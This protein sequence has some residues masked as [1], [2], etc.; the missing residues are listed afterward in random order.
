MEEFLSHNG[1]PFEL[2]N[3]FEDPLTPDELFDLYHDEDGIQLGPLTSLSHQAI[4]Y[5]CDL[6]RIGEHL[7]AHPDEIRSAGSSVWG[8]ADDRGTQIVLGYLGEHGVPSTLQDVREEPLSKPELWDLL[9]MPGEGILR[10]PLTV[11]DG[12][13]VL[14]FDLEWLRDALGDVGRQAKDLSPERLR[15][16][17]PGGPNAQALRQGRG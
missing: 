10:S 14:G 2:R 5:G 13:M 1:I 17:G 15:E 7:E 12:R 6:L 16:L 8:R 3:Q 11:V 9:Y 4:V